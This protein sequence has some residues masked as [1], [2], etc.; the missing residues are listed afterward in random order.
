MQ[1]VKKLKDRQIRK[2]NFIG[3]FIKTDKAEERTYLA[4]TLITGFLAALVAVSLHKVTHY[5]TDLIGSHEP[6]TLKTFLF[7]GLFILISGWLTTRKFPSTSGSGVPGVRIAL[8]VFHGKIKFQ[9]TLAKFVTS[10][11]SLSS[12]VSLGRE[13]PTV[14]IASGIGS[15]LGTFFQI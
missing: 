3:K 9:D 4:L 15:F 8:A 12:G 14:A 7:G 11:L 5:L 6:F 10:A 2:F 1:R 13:G